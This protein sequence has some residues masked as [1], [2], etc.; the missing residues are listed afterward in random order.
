MVA[1][2]TGPEALITHVT[3]VL[4]LRRRLELYDRSAPDTAVLQ[5]NHASANALRVEKAIQVECHVTV[6]SAKPV[7]RQVCVTT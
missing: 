7:A 5:H 4:E 2:G 1:A 6:F 3:L